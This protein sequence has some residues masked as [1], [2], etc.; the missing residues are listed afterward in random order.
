MLLT[1][2]AAWMIC[3]IMM[4]M[5]VEEA[6]DHMRSIHDRLTSGKLEPHELSTTYWQAYSFY[7]RNRDLMDVGYN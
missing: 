4:H 6:K 7:E 3:A 1:V 5:E 2:D